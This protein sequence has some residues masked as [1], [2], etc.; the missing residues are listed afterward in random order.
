MPS[1]VSFTDD[2]QL[3]SGSAKIALHSNPFN[4]VFD[5]KRLIGRK[6]DQ[7]DLRKDMKHQIDHSAFS[8]LPS[9]LLSSPRSV[10]S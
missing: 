5:A 6:M 1:C 7:A 9:P 3:V 8:D 4:D 10:D 2:E